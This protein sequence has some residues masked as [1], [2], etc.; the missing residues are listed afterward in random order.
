MTRIFR[1]L[2]LKDKEL[3]TIGKGLF[4]EGETVLVD[5]E[6]PKKL[7]RVIAGIK[8]FFDPTKD[9]DK[10][11]GVSVQDDSGRYYYDKIAGLDRI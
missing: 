7:S 1:Q 6:R 4:S 8:D 2:F 10:L 3:M 5:K 11:G 9:R